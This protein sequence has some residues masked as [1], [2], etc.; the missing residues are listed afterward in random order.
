MKENYL[1]IHFIHTYAQNINKR[2][3]HIKHINLNFEIFHR[4][5]IF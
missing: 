2:T 5:L 1:Q 4:D 3:I